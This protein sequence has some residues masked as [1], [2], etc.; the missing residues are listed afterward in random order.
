MGNDANNL[1]GIIAPSGQYG[2]DWPSQPVLSQGINGGL[3][4]AGWKE[5]TEGFPQ[6]TFLGASIRN[7]SINAGF[8][9]SVS[10]LSVDLVNDEFNL[11]DGTLLGSGDD[12]YH[13]GDTDQFLPPVVGTPVYF[14]FGGNLATTEQAYRRTFDDTYRTDTLDAP[15]D[16]VEFVT[17]GEIENI[18]GKHYYLRKIENKGEPDQTNTWI[19]KSPLHNIETKWRGKDHLVFG[20]ILQSYTQNRGPGGNPLYSLQVTDPRE[21]LSN[22]QVLLNNYAGTTFNNK[23]LLN[24]FGFLEHDPTEPTKKAI[25]AKAISKN[26]VRK[27]VNPA[28]GSFDYFGDDNYHFFDP[29]AFVPP[30]YAGTYFSASS[31]DP[32][33]DT[34]DSKFPITGQGFARRSERGMPWYRIR[35]GLNAL[36]GNNGFLPTEYEQAGYGGAIDFRGY[37]YVVDFGGIPTE[38]IPNGYFLDFDQIDLLSL[39]QELCDVIS[40]ELF[41]TLLPVIDHPNCKVIHDFNKD[42]ATGYPQ[43][44]SQ[45]I[46]GIIRVDAI[47]KRKPPTYGAIKSYLDFMIK[48]GVEVENQD[49]GYELSN[50]TT[51]KF[52]VGAQQVNMHYFTT[53]K[54]RND[55]ELKKKK[56]GKS[57]KLALLERDKWDLN[58]ML[59][60]QVVPF[61]GFLGAEKAVTI[62]KGF[63]SYQQIFLDAT[64]LNAFGVGNYYVAT[65]I[66]LRAALVSYQ[67]WKNFLLQYDE[68]WMR[69]LTGP[70]KFFDQHVPADVAKEIEEAGL[71]EEVTQM[72]KVAFDGNYGVSVPRCVWRS[73]K[74]Y[75]GKDGYPASPCSPPYG[76][77]LYYKRAEKIGIAEGG[78][79]SVINARTTM[80][81]NLSRL[82][83][84]LD[85]NAPY[86]DLKKEDALEE[87][88]KIEKAINLKWLQFKRA[89][90]NDILAKAAFAAANVSLYAALQ[91]AKNFVKKIEQDFETAEKDDKLMIAEI[92]DSISNNK[93]LIK[94]ASR[95][96]K[97][98]EKNAQKVYNFVK[99]VAEEN[100]G[101]KF[102]V[103]IPKKTNLNFTNKVSYFNNNANVSS[104]RTGPFGFRPLPT[105]ASNS[106][107]V[108]GMAWSQ[109]IANLSGDVSMK[110]PFEHY[111]DHDFV[112][113]DP[114]FEYGYSNGA[115]KCNYNPF[116]E[117][118]EYNYKPEPQGGYVD[119]T[120]RG[121]QHAGTIQG[122]NARNKSAFPNDIMD[123]LSPIDP[124]NMMMS[125]NRMSAYMRFD[126]SH[127]YDFSKISSD[128][129]SQQSINSYGFIVPDVME[130]LD[131]VDPDQTLTFAEVEARKSEDKLL[132]R[133]DPSIAFVKCDV[134]E[135][136]Y[137]PPRMFTVPTR[138]FA[139]G[140]KVVVPTPRVEIINVTPEDDPATDEDESKCP[141]PSGVVRKV[142]PVFSPSSERRMTVNTVDFLKGNAV[143]GVPL[144]NDDMDIVGIDSEMV[145]IVAGSKV[146]QDPNH[147]Y[148]LVT[149][150]GMVTSTVDIRYCDGP[151]SAYET[152]HM[153]NL[154]T[155]D[156]VKG[157]RGFNQPAEITNGVQEATCKTLQ[158]FSVGEINEARATQKQVL[159]KAASASM[160]GRLSFT[161]PSPVY[162]DMVAIPLMSMERCYGPWLSNASLNPQTLSPGVTNIGGKLEFV[163]DESLSP[164]NFGGYKLMNDAGYLQ[165]QFSNSLLL[166][167]ER[168]GFVIPQAPTGVGLAKSLQ[169]GGP[170]VTSIN[171]NI[172]QNKISTTVKMDLYTSSFGKLQKQ[173]EGN[174]AQMTREKQKLTDQRNSAIRRGMGKTL[175]NKNFYESVLKGGGAELIKMAKESSQHFS[176][177]EKGKTEDN[178]MMIA[179]QNSWSNGKPQDFNG[180]VSDTV[181]DLVKRGQ[182]YIQTNTE[183]YNQM[184]AMAQDTVDQLTDASEVVT[185]FIGDFVNLLSDNIGDKTRP[186][187]PQKPTKRVEDR[188]GPDANQE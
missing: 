110:H 89:Y 132:E 127:L 17:E 96:A 7:F 36:M 13:N 6:Q 154:Q 71:S 104:I 145:Q 3:S 123:T 120:L 73:D 94:N 8:G 133:Q 12:P 99:K 151:R 25:E 70:I 158:N 83:D 149:L 186:Q 142:I 170:L 166:F 131:N 115:L 187:V 68:Q 134:D 72:L 117:K 185:G 78:I 10:T 152:A 26:V 125:S 105:T 128:S 155:R 103:K 58:T 165:A 16:F 63:G 93:K 188:R 66:E 75:L 81:S 167:T 40:H 157:V 44:K 88:K 161:S 85:T 178:N 82:N 173:K 21:I 2:N 126:N 18:P 90:S 174:I 47:D 147:V 137:M 48:N 107:Y 95:L 141:V 156:V 135:E 24:V 108:T 65:E 74:N 175:S 15:V 57:N 168:G 136:F 20:G 28:D 169:D 39:A 144:Y 159:K 177:F 27:I 102:L 91:E 42:I 139:R 45:M 51:D 52:V 76:Y 55:I 150:P 101:K 35:D 164:W 180:L 37:K 9:D 176:D 183:K 32:F 140:F 30:S 97:E 148:A 118:W 146:N 171:V 34:F 179:A 92:K 84:K 19:D 87:V 109:T 41:V 182:S 1:L 38:L 23:N 163:K 80:T 46:A 77:P 49:L 54:D 33:K 143:D 11:S 130:D 112:H 116:A 153:Y 67:Q 162:P 31:T 79:I 69:K 86:F 160:D 29:T 59:K 121:F 98:G 64:S 43:F 56:D 53:N 181:G 114:N 138:V 184:Q 61:Y 22:A 60:Q 172:T 106:Y 50:V 119:H 4:D 129:L 122:M 14:K 62:P 124:Q 113:P 5:G 111:L 100:L